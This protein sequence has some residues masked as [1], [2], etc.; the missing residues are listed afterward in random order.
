MST[1]LRQLSDR[2]IEILRLVSGGLSNQQIALQL[3]I[4]ANTVKVHLRN[5][6]AKIGA[7]SRTE[8][9]LYAVRTGLVTVHNIAPPVAE[10]PLDLQEPEIAPPLID[11]PPTQAVAEPEPTAEPLEVA[12]QPTPHTPTER[13]VAQSDAIE[14]VIATGRARDT[15][16]FRWV[17]FAVL[18]IALLGGIAGTAWINRRAGATT[19]PT[20]PAQDVATPGQGVATSGQ[21]VAATASVVASSRWRTLPAPDE[22]RAAFAI[23]AV[24]DVIYAIGGEN[25]EGILASVARFDPRFGTWTTLSRKPTAVADVH[26]VVLGG[27]IY[28]PGGRTSP[29]PADISDVLERYDPR[30][31]TWETLAPLP[32]PRSAYALAALEGKLYLFGGW[33]G[34]GY[35]SEVFEY[36][37]DA[38][39]W[40]ERTAMPT[41]RA[42][43]G[44]AVVDAS[45]Y[46]LG[47]ENDEGDLRSNEAYTPTE[48]GAQPWARRAPLPTPRSHFGAAA[49]LTLIH[50]IGGT[51]AGAPPLQYN[52]RSDNW[53]PFEASP[54][55]VGSQPGVVLVETNIVGL[56]GM[57]AA[58]TYATDMQSYQALF[59]TVLP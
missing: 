49:V 50:V 34:T 54:T 36:D 21:S 38:D 47:G 10:E 31:E 33:D 45:V 16:R 41:A 44:A 46:V 52:V 22:A 51:D 17:V 32:E 39:A 11:E 26:S 6:F 15:R 3:G 2:E 25:D 4:S 58:G 42:F 29:D 27:R 23:A 53:K 37:P 9:T 28:V 48:E 20:A 30:T 59:T 35:R 18:A 1:D 40:R 7:A 56:G 55:P 8:A 5:I 57:P 13:A 19:T 14:T 24:N 43:A 12:P